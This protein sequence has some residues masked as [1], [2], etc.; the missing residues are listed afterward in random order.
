MPFVYHQRSGRL[1]AP[2]GSVLAVGYAGYDDG[3]GVPEPGEGKNDP[4]ME[5]VKM[6]GPLPAGRW[7]MGPAFDHA[8]LGTC[9]IPLLPLPGT[10]TYGR[11]G[12]LVHGDSRKQPGAGSHG[13]VVMPLAVRQQLAAASD[14]VLEVVA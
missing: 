12:F 10:R 9:C 5:R 3:D 1:A 2:D 13:C 14:R 8:R 7:A 4:G 11:S 6:V